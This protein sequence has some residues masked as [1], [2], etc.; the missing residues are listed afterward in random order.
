MQLCSPGWRRFGRSASCWTVAGRLVKSLVVR[1]I[2]SLW[3]WPQSQGWHALGA[4][5]A[6]EWKVSSFQLVGF[7]LSGAGA[8]WAQPPRMSGLCCPCNSFC[9]EQGGRDLGAAAAHG[10]KVLSSHAV[11]FELSGAGAIRRSCRSSVKRWF[12]PCDRCG[13]EWGWRDLGAAAAHE[14]KVVSLP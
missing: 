13:V 10:W 1:A 14:R 11:G 2:K 12:S 6:H 4:A 9:V 3:V 7:V 5:A 8:M